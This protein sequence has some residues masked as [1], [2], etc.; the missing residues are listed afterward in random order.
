MVYFIL[1]TNI[2]SGEIRTF[3]LLKQEEVPVEEHR[4]IIHLKCKSVRRMNGISNLLQYLQQNSFNAMHQ[5]EPYILKKVSWNQ[6]VDM[7][8]FDYDSSSDNTESETTST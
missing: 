3:Y 5:Q 4:N 7:F 8:G 2:T 1:K 6:V